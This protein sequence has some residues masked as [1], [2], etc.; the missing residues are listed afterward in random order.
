M[1]Q[2]I[3]IVGVDLIQRERIDANGIVHISNLIELVAEPVD[4]FKVK[5]GSLV[6]FCGFVFVYDR[7]VGADGI[8]LSELKS[9]AVTTVIDIGYEYEVMVS[10]R[11]K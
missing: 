1:K 7:N 10:K 8:H 3:S 9:G 5:R 2:R 4:A 11:G 6:E